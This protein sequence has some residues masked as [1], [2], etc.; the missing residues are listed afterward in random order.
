MFIITNRNL[1]VS[2]K[3][4]D[5]FGSRHGEGGA[6]DLRLVE[7]TRKSS[8]KYDVRIVPNWVTENDTDL[9]PQLVLS[10]DERAAASVPSDPSDDPNDP[11]ARPAAPA[12]L[13]SRYAAQ[14]IIKGVNS[15]RDFV[16]FVHGFNVDLKGAVVR[17][18]QFE[19]DFGVE[20]VIFS[21]PAKGGGVGGTMNYRDDKRDA[22][23]SAGALD[24]AIEKVHGYLAC[25]REEA[26]A[27]IMRESVERFPEDRERQFDFVNRKLEKLCPH[28]LTLVCHSMGN[29]VLKYALQSSTAY[30]SGRAVFDNIVLVAPDTNHQGHESWVGRLQARNRLYVCINEDDFALAASRAKVGAEQT[31]RLGHSTRL[32][33]SSNAMYVDFTDAKA[34]GRSHGYFDVKKS[35][36]PYVFDFF[37]RAMKG[38]RAEADGSGELLVYYP[39]SDTY[40]PQE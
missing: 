16:L 29:Y 12:V 33:H 13:G 22:R 4:F 36:N 14:K 40:R 2:N 32:P 27:D 24:R 5:R 23:S 25:F 8:G 21:W 9:W 15:G 10:A 35:A 37:K 3:G 28:S 7:V 34:V 38:Q 26:T 18:E 17:A 1:I 20:V 39:N 6:N 30:A 31:A 19:K 11:N